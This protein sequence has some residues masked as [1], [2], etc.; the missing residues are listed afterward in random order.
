M[1]G[2]IQ[3]FLLPAREFAEKTIKL[4]KSAFKSWGIMADW[5]KC[6]FTF[7][8]EFEAK[9]LEIFF[10]MYEKVWCQYVFFLCTSVSVSFSRSEKFSSGQTTYYVIFCWQQGFVYQ[11][12]MPVFW[13]PSSRY[14]SQTLAQNVSTRLF[15]GTALFQPAIVSLQDGSCGSRTGIQW[16]SQEYCCLCEVSHQTCLWGPRISLG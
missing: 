10:Q 16:A 13:S 12:Y 1:F 15:Y 8:K 11:S 2:R 5:S 3:H 6:Y 9:Q 7:D 4:Q 14:M